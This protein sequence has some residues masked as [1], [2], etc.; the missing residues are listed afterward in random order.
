M[1]T[2]EFEIKLPAVMLPVADTAFDVLS[3]V[4]AAEPFRMSP[5]L[6]CMLVLAPPASIL[7]L[8][9]PIKFCAV[10]LPLNTA[11]V[12]VTLE[13]ALMLPPMTLPTALILPASL[14]LTLS[15]VLVKKLMYPEG[16]GAR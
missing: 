14:M 7:P 2:S 10:T 11:P 15:P 9:L 12:P 16:P 6:N 4:N 5:S 8:I 13:V 3:N 1:V